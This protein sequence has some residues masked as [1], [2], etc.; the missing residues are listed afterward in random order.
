MVSKVVKKLCEN[1][2]NGFYTDV[3]TSVDC[4]GN[5]VAENISEFES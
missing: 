5:N 2:V 3:V 1:M 4:W